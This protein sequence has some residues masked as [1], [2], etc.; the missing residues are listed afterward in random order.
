MAG[1][2]GSFEERNGL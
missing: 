2:S 1:I